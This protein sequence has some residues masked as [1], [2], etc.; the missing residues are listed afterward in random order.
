MR[1]QLLAT[2]DPEIFTPAANRMNDILWK[3]SA[4][5]ALADGRSVISTEDVVG[6]LGHAE[7][8]LCNLATVA[9]GIAETGFSRACNEIEKLIATSKTQELD[10]SA[11]YRSRP[12]EP[13]RIV[14]EY[15]TSLKR[16]GRVLETQANAGAAVFYKLRK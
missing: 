13:I 9:D 15:L 14:D 11:I 1:Q 10:Q 8:W 4:L 2:G 3:V 5:L 7:E 16:Q 12:G 6:A